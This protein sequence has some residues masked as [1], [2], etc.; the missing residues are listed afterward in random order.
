MNIITKKKIPTYTT[1]FKKDATNLVK[2]NYTHKDA[3]KN[4]GS[5]SA[6]NRW[7]KAESHGDQKVNLNERAELVRLRKEPAKVTMEREILKK[8]VVFFAKEGM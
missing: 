8:A 6:L 5:L 4:L 2:N 3:A 1:K 7:I